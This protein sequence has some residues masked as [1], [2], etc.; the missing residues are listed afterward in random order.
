MKQVKSRAVIVINSYFAPSGFLTDV[1]LG[2]GLGILSEFDHEQVTLDFQSNWLADSLHR[3]LFACYSY[4]K[5]KIHHTSAEV[6][7]CIELQ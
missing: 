4:L 5:L 7:S 1:Y 2:D 6:G 3:Q